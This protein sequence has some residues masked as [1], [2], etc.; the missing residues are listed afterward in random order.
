MSRVRRLGVCLW[1]V[2]GLVGLALAAPAPAGE[3]AKADQGPLADVVAEAAALGPWR[4]LWDGKTTQ[5]W[6]EIGK[7]EWLIQDGAIVGRH[8]QAE[9]EFSHLVTDAVYRDFTIRLKY[10]TVVGNSG[11]YFRIEEKGG[12]GVSGFQAEIDPNNDAGGL[13]ETNGRAWVVQPPAEKVKTWFKPGEWNE[14]IVTAIGGNVIV[15]VNGLRS[16]ALIDDPG[17]R[18][19]HIALQL[20]GG[21]EGEVF[22]KD[23]EIVEWKDLLPGPG[24]AGWKKPTGDWEMVGRAVKDPNNER[25]LSVETGK[26]TIYNGAKGATGNLFTDSDHGDVAAH[27][28]FMVPKGSNSGVY[29]MGRYEIQVYDSYG[30]AKGEY[31]GIECGGIYE[32]WDPGRGQ[33]KEG[34]EGR[35]PRVNA[36]F[37]PGEWQS[38]DVVFLAP[39]FGPDGKKTANGKFV[40]V[41]HN[42]AVIHENVE[43]SGPTRAAAFDDEKPLGPLMIQGDH[44]PVGYRNMKILPLGK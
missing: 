21:Q 6:H 3:A 15:H 14:M 30:V 34:F 28:E 18:E 19:G 7:G 13:Y 22:F 36:S 4:P 35:S 44:G 42:G 20:H 31:P 43:V 38:Y 33:G 10:K 27:I 12:S 41:V 29:F 5:G 39:R 2:G 1:A 16:A 17:R 23:I 37:P 24:M 9:G 40:K 11:L 26:G 25:A 32:R 8:A